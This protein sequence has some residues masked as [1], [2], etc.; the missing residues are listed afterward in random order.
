MAICWKSFWKGA[1]IGT[2]I[3]EEDDPMLAKALRRSQED[4]EKAETFKKREEEEFQRAINESL[5]SDRS[6]SAAQASGSDESLRLQLEDTPPVDA[7]SN[8]LIFFKKS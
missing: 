8:S 4:Y 3:L 5:K 6:I 2:G 1:A 7:E